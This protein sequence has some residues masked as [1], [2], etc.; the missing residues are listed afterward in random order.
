MHSPARKIAPVSAPSARSS[1]PLKKKSDTKRYGSWEIVSAASG[2][3]P[4]PGRGKRKVDEFFGS[5]KSLRST[6]RKNRARVAPERLGFTESKKGEENDSV[7]ARSVSPASKSANG[8]GGTS[9]AVSSPTK[10]PK[11]AKRAPTSA[12]SFHRRSQQIVAHRSSSAKK[13][14]IDLTGKKQRRKKAAQESTT[15][16]DSEDSSSESDSAPSSA[17]SSRSSSAS[18]APRSRADSVTRKKSPAVKA[19]FRAPVKAAAVGRVKV[20]LAPA[21]AP[22]KSSARAAKASPKSPA[23]A[24]QRLSTTGLRVPIP[25]AARRLALS[26]A[27]LMRSLSA[28]RHTR[29]A[30]S[31][32]RE[33]EEEREGLTPSPRPFTPFDDVSESPTP[34]AASAAANLGSPWTFPRPATPIG[35]NLDI[36][37]SESAKHRLSLSSVL[38]PSKLNFD[39][40]KRRAMQY[41]MRSAD[42]IAA[43]AIC[44]KEHPNSAYT[45]RLGEMGTLANGRVYVAVSNNSD[46]QLLYLDANSKSDPAMIEKI[47]LSQ[48][49]K[50]IRRA[51]DSSSSESEGEQFDI[52]TQLGPAEE[53]EIRE[54]KKSSAKKQK[55]THQRST[56]PAPPTG[57]EA[58][59]REGAAPSP[60]S[61]ASAA[62]SASSSSAAVAPAAPTSSSRATRKVI[63]MLGLFASQDIRVGEWVTE[64]GGVLEWEGFVKPRPRESNTHIRRIANSDMVWNGRPWSLLF[65]RVPSTLESELNRSMAERV[66]LHPVVTERSIINLLLLLHHEQETHAKRFGKGLGGAAARE[67]ADGV[68]AS[69][70]AAAA[71]AASAAST[72]GALNVL[73]P[74]VPK[75]ALGRLGVCRGNCDQCTSQMREVHRAHRKPTTLTPDFSLPEYSKEDVLATLLP[76]CCCCSVQLGLLPCEVTAVVTSWSAADYLQLTDLCD[77]LRQQWVFEG[78]M[79]F[80]ANTEAKVRQNVRSEPM[81]R[82]KGDIGA[83]KPRVNIYIATKD[84]KAGEEILVAYNNNESKQM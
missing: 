40:V 27:P 4:L 13:N 41:I 80:M 49:T 2:P 73:Q 60:A 32:N 74:F 6:D 82:F 8:S 56:T 51:G 22:A 59:G 33:M 47:K 24:M 58:E 44:M 72:A 53:G 70:A 81:S 36:K 84:I 11:I 30:H 77:Q 50:W 43:D 66:R 78:G 15:E 17:S 25:S 42:E 55:K 38:H 19:L 71:A 83:M 5:I 52:E 65:P 29:Q 67:F 48:S 69:V 7:A 46:H 20:R 57:D 28:P 39:W 9:S 18:P 63:P 62:S 45:K 1:S 10:L 16:S 76:Q 31:G 21:S 68:A 34:L 14:V 26:P 35:G 37:L 79:G 64:Y 54:S 23:T 12:D 3:G 75:E 61:A